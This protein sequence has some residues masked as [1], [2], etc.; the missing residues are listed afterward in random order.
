MSDK[1]TPKK[2]KKISGYFLKIIVSGVILYFLFSTLN[3]SQLSTVF[4]TVGWSTI[5]LVFL[6]GVGLWFIEYLR[7][8]IATRAI[9]PN[10]NSSRFLRVFFSGYAL[11]F[12]IP[13]GLGEVG[14]MM[15][16]PGSYSRRLI[17]YLAD[18]GSLALAVF[19][20][21]LSGVWRVYPQMRPYYWILLVVIPAL[22]LIVRYFVR[23]QDLSL[24]GDYAYPVK[25]VLGVTIPLSFLHVF[26]MA[27]QYWLVLKSVQI[28]FSAVFTTV[29]IVLFAVMIP[30]SFAGIGVR[31]WTTMQMLL[32]F[33]ISKETALVA[34]LL[35]FVCNVFIPALIGVAV[36]LI[37]KMKPALFARNQIDLH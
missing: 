20:G 30:I 13:G 24:S 15:F 29:N 31:E 23:K 18:K 37:F 28:P 19:V 35:V 17:A 10:D 5:C 4:L 22:F 16:V 27:L 3:L 7:F 36:I 34:P 9:L 26:I 33:E 2:L 25:K 11:R 21:G 6:A 32:H 1:T 8:Y 14:K 12:V